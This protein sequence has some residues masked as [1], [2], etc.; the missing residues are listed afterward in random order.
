MVG[1]MGI[2]FDRGRLFACLLPPPICFVWLFDVI[3]LVSRCLVWNFPL[4]MLM[5]FG[6]LCLILKL[7]GMMMNWIHHFVL[8]SLISDWHR[9]GLKSRMKK[10]GLKPSPR[11]VPPP[12]VALPCKLMVLSAVMMSSWSVAMA[13]HVT[14][15]PPVTWIEAGAGV[16]GLEHP[17]PPP[18]SPSQENPLIPLFPQEL[19]REKKQ[20]NL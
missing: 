2:P 16:R 12:L 9:A 5:V 15:A 13:G 18:S 14:L 10:K 17:C 20:I 7:H 8:A 19:E 3:V 11:P 4:E 1:R 6:V